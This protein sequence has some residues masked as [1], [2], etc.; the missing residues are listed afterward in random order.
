MN[1]IQSERQEFCRRV[2]RPIRCHNCQKLGDIRKKCKNMSKSES[3]YVS[4]NKKRLKLRK[5]GKSVHPKKKLT[6]KFTIALKYEKNE[7][8]RFT[9]VLKCV[10]ETEK[11]HSYT[12][13]I[14]SCLS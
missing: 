4:Y 10:I 7:K 2:R 6:Q 11:E 1:R 5:I 13:V 3:N 14:R 12:I 9:K 8:I